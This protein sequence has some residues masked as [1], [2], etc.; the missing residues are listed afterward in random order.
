VGARAGWAQVNL[1]ITDPLRRYK[2]RGPD[3]G[4]ADLLASTSL[5]RPCTPPQVA[6]PSVTLIAARL[7]ALATKLAAAEVFQAR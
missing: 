5:P 4:W 3:F 6:A 2:L 7:F 1:S